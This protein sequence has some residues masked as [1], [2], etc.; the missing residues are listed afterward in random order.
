MS[1]PQQRPQIAE[2]AKPATFLDAVWLPC[3]IV[4]IVL[5]LAGAIPLAAT[6]YRKLVWPQVPAV[7]LE[8]GRT[9]ASKK[10]VQLVYSLRGPDG[11]AVRSVDSISAALAEGMEPGR[12]IVAHCRPVDFA[13]CQST[14]SLDSWLALGGSILG[15]GAAMLA[16]GLWRRRAVRLGPT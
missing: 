14:I 13:E 15:P 11:R 10:K 7:V 5:T 3:L 8:L 4:G 12:A 1:V 16:F 6:L 9:N 2:G